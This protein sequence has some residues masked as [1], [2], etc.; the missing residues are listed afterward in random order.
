MGQTKAEYIA[1]VTKRCLIET[2]HRKY[3]EEEQ[4]IQWL[5]K[6]RKIK[7]AQQINEADRF[8]DS[9]FIQGSMEALR[10]SLVK[11]RFCCKN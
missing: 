8:K 10:D 1:S 9:P 5:R 6:A 7:S 2:I 4:V 3:R 11:K